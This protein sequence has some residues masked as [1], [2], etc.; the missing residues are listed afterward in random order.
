MCINIIT[1]KL[2]KIQLNHRSFLVCF[3]VFWL[4]VLFFYF[5]TGLNEGGDSAWTQLQ[6]SWNPLK[7][8]PLF[9]SMCFLVQHRG[10]NTNVVL[11]VS[12]RKLEVPEVLMVSFDAAFCRIPSPLGREGKGGE[13]R[14]ILFPRVFLDLCPRHTAVA[15]GQFSWRSGFLPVLGPAEGP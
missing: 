13:L 10:I 7:L 14:C 2:L 5:E 1:P 8:L 11:G 6:V 15:G 3:W 12:R 4:V 9:F